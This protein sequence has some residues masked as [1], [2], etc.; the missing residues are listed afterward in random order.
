MFPYPVDALKANRKKI[1]QRESSIKIPRQHSTSWLLANAAGAVDGNRDVI[2]HGY[3]AD[4]SQLDT[5]RGKRRLL[6]TH[7]IHVTR[8]AVKHRYFLLTEV[9]DTSYL[10]LK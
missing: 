2:N 7:R 5:T 6:D 1:W 9:T 3:H 8:D 10:S 4:T